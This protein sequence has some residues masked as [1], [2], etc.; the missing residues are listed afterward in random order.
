MDHVDRDIKSFEGQNL[1]R[2]ALDQVKARQTDPWP[3]MIGCMDYVTDSRLES[4]FRGYIG[5]SGK[6]FSRIMQNH[7]QSILHCKNNS[8]HYFMLWIGNGHRTA[9]FIRLWSFQDSAS[10]GE[11]YDAKSDILELLFCVFFNSSRW[12]V[13]PGRTVIKRRQLGGD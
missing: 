2:Q 6:G 5:Q 8:L 13:S 9:N 11:W 1:S 12:E 7:A 3:K 4:Y 10:Q